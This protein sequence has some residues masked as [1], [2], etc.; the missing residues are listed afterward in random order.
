MGDCGFCLSFLGDKFFSL[1]L[2][3]FGG[4]FYVIC[5]MAR[6]YCRLPRG[7]LSAVHRNV[8]EKDE[9]LHYT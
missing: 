2:T 7:I 1:S 4:W 5:H 8:R 9:K 6:L 3:D